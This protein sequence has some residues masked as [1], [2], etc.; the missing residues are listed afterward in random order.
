MTAVKFLK[1]P[2]V[3]RPLYD[4]QSKVRQLSPQKDHLE[5][6]RGETLATGIRAFCGKEETHLKFS[7]SSRMIRP[8]RAIVMLRLTIAAPFFP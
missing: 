5:E 2:I 7:H 4:L 8:V 6:S 3:C 1:G